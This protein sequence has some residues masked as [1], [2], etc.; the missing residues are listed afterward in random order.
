MIVKIKYFRNLLSPNQYI[1]LGLV[2]CTKM[3]H[4]LGIY[5]TY[6]RSENFSVHIV[7]SEHYK[8][9]RGKSFQSKYFQYISEFSEKY[10]TMYF[11]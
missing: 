9:Y 10:C 2:T 3:K 1:E 4:C 7:G 8:K 11:I 6:R 5:F